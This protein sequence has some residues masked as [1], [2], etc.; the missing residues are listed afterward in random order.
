MDHFEFKRITE[1]KDQVE[2]FFSLDRL[3]ELKSA[4]SY[5][6]ERAHDQVED[7]IVGEKKKALKDAYNILDRA[8]VEIE[9]IQ[10]SILSLLKSSKKK[11]VSAVAKKTKKKVVA[12]KKMVLKKKSR[13]TQARAH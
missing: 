9:S 4:I 5:Y 8:R 1:I 3:Q 2:S 6:L 7:R 11:S 10:K 13:T 12:K